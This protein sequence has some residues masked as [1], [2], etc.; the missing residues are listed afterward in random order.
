MAS[1]NIYL[2]II[3][4]NIQGIIKFLDNIISFQFL[5]L[6]SHL[7]IFFTFQNIET[8]IIIH[9][10]ICLIHSL[11]SIRNI[12]LPIKEKLSQTQ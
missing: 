7:N 1:L 5:R 9:V 6:L 2:T 10:F 3:L 4:I 8:L 11:S 12:C